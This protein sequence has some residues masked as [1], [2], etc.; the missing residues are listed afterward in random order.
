MCLS[1][2]NLGDLDIRILDYCSQVPCKSV[3]QEPQ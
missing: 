3:P 2:G 1:L